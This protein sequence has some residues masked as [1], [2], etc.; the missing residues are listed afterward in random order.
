MNFKF[1]KAKEV[2]IQF[3]KGVTDVSSK[4]HELL[5][6]SKN[7]EIDNFLLLSFGDVLGLPI[8]LSYY[9][10]E[11]LPFLEDELKGWDIRMSTKKSIWIEK[12]GELNMDP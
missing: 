11:L 7:E 4:S 3:L 6:N 2:T 5:K 10:L 1:S 8:P 12:A 9:S